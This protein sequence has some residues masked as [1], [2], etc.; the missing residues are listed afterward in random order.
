MMA[1]WALEQRIW[2]PS[3]VSTASSCRAWWRFCGRVVCAP[4]HGDTNG[5]GAGP[6]AGPSMGVGIV[7][8]GPSVRIADV[9]DDKD[10]NVAL[11]V[12]TRT[13]LT[14]FGKF[15]DENDHFCSLGTKLS[16]RR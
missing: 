10:D 8:H 7:F 3:S 16:F 1:L 14:R 5:G 2:R 4:D 15:E 12:S 6:C 9:D 11:H 13:K